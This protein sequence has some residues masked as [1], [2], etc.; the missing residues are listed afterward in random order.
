MKSIRLKKTLVSLA[1]LT[2]S[3]N[4]RALYHV[5]IITHVVLKG[6]PEEE[7]IDRQIVGEHLDILCDEGY[8]E[9]AVIVDNP[10]GTSESARYAYGANMEAVEKLK[11]LPELAEGD[12]EQ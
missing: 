2:E 5:P 10:S 3:A 8:A 7:G 1:H 6:F 11:D 9:R 4:E 12:T